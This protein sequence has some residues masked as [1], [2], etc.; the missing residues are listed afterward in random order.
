MLGCWWRRPFKSHMADMLSEVGGRSGENTLRQGGISVTAG[1]ED[2][3]GR[4]IS[5]RTRSFT[6]FAWLL[7][8]PTVGNCLGVAGRLPVLTA[9]EVRPEQPPRHPLL[10]VDRARGFPAKLEFGNGLGETADR[11]EA[12]RLSFG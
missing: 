9:R 8:A 3:N 7:L 4:L 5:A 6:G 2:L 1:P 10:L 11:L 12:A